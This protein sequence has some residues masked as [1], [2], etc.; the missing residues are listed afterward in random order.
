MPTEWQ[1][2]YDREGNF[3][4]HRGW[5]SPE[6]EPPRLQAPARNGP[7]ISGISPYCLVV[8]F[9]LYAAYFPCV[10]ISHLLLTLFPN[11]FPVSERDG[12]MPGTILICFLILV[13]I[14]ITVGVCWIG[15]VWGYPLV[16]GTDDN[17]QTWRSEKRPSRFIVFLRLLFWVFCLMYMTGS[18]PFGGLFSIR[19]GP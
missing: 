1:I 6:P 11:V 16:F 5:S 9:A 2:G 15:T 3:S 10:A 19:T 4:L 13:G 17:P 12:N 18:F 7:G 8:G 14:S